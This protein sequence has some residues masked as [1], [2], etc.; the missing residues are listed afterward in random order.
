MAAEH[1][2][3]LV[4]LS[5]GFATFH[6]TRIAELATKHRIPALYGHSQYTEAGGL[7]SY[8]SSYSDAFVRAP[9]YVDRILKGE[10]P[11]NLPVQQP[12]KFELILNLKAANAIG[13]SFP[14]DIVAL[15]DRVIE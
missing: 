1:I 7:M 10:Q 14:H 9:A 3:G 13:I 6:R 12:T 2:D 11:A 8:G 5:D 15:A 4:V